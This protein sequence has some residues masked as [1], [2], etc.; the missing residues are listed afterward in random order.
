MA[1]IIITIKDE[2]PVN[3]MPGVS[4][5]WEGDFKPMED[6]ATLTR[7]QMRANTLK[8]LLDWAESLPEPGN[9][10]PN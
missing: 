1:E 6:G 8:A 3:G 5:S 7:A 4:V 10:L 9:A 2:M